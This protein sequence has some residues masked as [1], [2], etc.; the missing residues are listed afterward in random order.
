[1]TGDVRVV[2]PDG[3]IEMD[4]RSKDVII[5]ENICCNEVEEALFRHLAVADAAVVAMPYAHWGKTPC[6]IAF[7]RREH[8][9]RFIV[10]K[11]VVVWD[12]L[13][14]NAVGKVEKVKLR[15]AAQKSCCQP[16]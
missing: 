1:M 16:W 8:M 11:K 10:P 9:V 3:Y 6:M 4:D 2:H 12:V 14:R 5:S 13:P 7:C 15:E